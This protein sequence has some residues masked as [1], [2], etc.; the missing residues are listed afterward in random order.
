M[1]CPVYG[2]F[3]KEIGKELAWQRRV[4]DCQS[5][6]RARELKIAIAVDGQTIADTTGSQ[7]ALAAS[8][9]VLRH[10]ICTLR[11]QGFLGLAADVYLTLL[12][13]FETARAHSGKHW[14]MARSIKPIEPT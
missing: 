11:G 13:S 3:G 5:P 2:D 7:L 14:I 6:T 12:K 8:A 10:G 9:I 4:A 1:H